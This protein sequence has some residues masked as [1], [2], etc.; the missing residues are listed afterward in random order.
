MQMITSQ[1][2]HYYFIFILSIFLQFREHRAWYLL[3]IFKFQSISP[4]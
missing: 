4:K 3:I 2:F 1:T